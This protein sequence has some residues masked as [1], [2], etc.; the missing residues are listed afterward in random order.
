[1]LLFALLGCVA[2]LRPIIFAKTHKTGSSTLNTILYRKAA[3]MRWKVMVPDDFVHFNY[4]W[5]FKPPENG[6][7]DKEHRADLHSYDALL[8]HA[9]FNNEK[10]SKFMKPEP[11]VV[12]TL[13]NPVD[14]LRSSMQFYASENPA[15]SD[16]HGAI[17]KSDW[18][19]LNSWAMKC[20]GQ[21]GVCANG[22]TFDLG[23]FESPEHEEALQKLELLD[24]QSTNVVHALC[25]TPQFQ[26][27]MDRLSHELSFVAILEHFDESLVLLGRAYGLALHELIYIPKKVVFKERGL[28]DTLGEEVTSHP[29]MKEE[30]KSVRATPVNAELALP[31]GEMKTRAE[32]NNLCDKKL[33]AFYNESLWHRW[34]ET[35][36]ETNAFLGPRR[37]P[38]QD[39][40]NLRRMNKEIYD[41]CGD[42]TNSDKELCKIL[43]MDSWDFTKWYALSM[44]CSS[45]DGCEPLSPL[46]DASSMLCDVI[47]C[48]FHT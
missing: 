31:E 42:E 38:T 25:R 37:T 19:F 29:W 12:T 20:E 36:L 2:A 4:P 22:Q 34:H 47:D 15:T 18:A 9:V 8:N 32:E 3:A 41:Y 28:K 43:F 39:L 44:D 1:M 6:V 35:N 30:G 10:M 7:K 24:T 16:Y 14:R 40:A 11:F 17:S 23:W 46:A 33:H 21:T 48:T 27:W 26:S 45:S 13:R 5:T